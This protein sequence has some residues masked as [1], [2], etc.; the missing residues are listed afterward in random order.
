MISPD[1]IKTKAKIKYISLL[2][3]MIQE[4][5]FSKIIIRGDK[6]YSKSSLVDF[7]KE[8]L[9]IS[10]SSKEK[11]GFGYTL[12]FQKVKTKHLGTQDIPIAIYFDSEKDLLKYLDKEREFAFFKLDC[13]KIISTF[14]ELKDWAYQN[15]SKIIQNQPEWEGILKVCGY[16]KNT[17]KPNLYIRELPVSVHTKFIE[18]N[19]SI[20]REL[21]NL[22]IEPHINSQEN[23]F[24][25]RFNLKYS[26]A[27]VRFK[28]LDKN[29][30]L[31][32]FSGVDDISIPISQFENLKL[33]LK[34]VAPLVCNE[35]SPNCK[36]QLS[37]ILSYE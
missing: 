15:P 4:I 35:F 37:E 29:I 21:L 22:I 14:P 11:K 18:C 28:V 3:S 17:P 7:E 26:D 27:L 25:K 24:E 19:K 10:S 8:I 31:T 5:P 1:E 23:D 36:F 6:T 9:A 30:S 13:E 33:P 20:L 2:Q 12:E 34:K 32:Y 16:F